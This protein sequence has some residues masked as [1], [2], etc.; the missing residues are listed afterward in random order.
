MGNCSGV[1]A[2]PRGT[3]KLCLAWSALRLAWVNQHLI[4]TIKSPFGNPA[5]SYRG[6]PWFCAPASRRVCL[7]VAKSILPSGERLA[8][9]QRPLG[10]AYAPEECVEG[11]FCEVG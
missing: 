3:I 4:S 10:L 2:A 8:Q 11:E 6:G 5:A 7:F 1:F 9:P